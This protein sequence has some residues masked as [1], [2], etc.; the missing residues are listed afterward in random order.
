MCWG[1]RNYLT[2]LVPRVASHPSVDAVLVGMPQSVDVSHRDHLGDT[3]ELIS[4]RCTLAAR[5]REVNRP[6]KRKIERFSPD[7]IFIPTARH[8]RLNGIPVVNMVRNMMPATRAYS[9]DYIEYAKNWAR[10]IQMRQAV[11]KARRVIAVSKFVGRYLCEDLGVASENIGIVYHGTPQ[12]CGRRA[13]RPVLVSD[14]WRRR[15]VF[16]AGSIYPYRGIEDVILACARMKSPPYVV[17]AGFVGHRMGKYH[18][19]LKE[20]VQ[21]TRLS[22]QIRFVGA[23]TREEMGWCYQNCAAFVMSSR[24]EACPNIAL[25][26]MAHGCVCISTLNPPMPEIFGDA[27]RY[28]A[29]G[30][31]AELVEQLTAALHLSVA[32]QEEAR[33]EAIAT[34]A[35]FSW[36]ACCEK[37]IE[38]LQKVA[39][40]RDQGDAFN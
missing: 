29:A 34:A 33:H 27:A 38:E 20:L 36:D 23:L 4:L 28:Y 11:H 26:A 12:P 17:I 13:K 39:H 1:Y 15:F 5:G 35:K 21:T 32:Q 22:S 37:T 18:D 6:E 3:V 7:V 2:E 14:E 10:L 24:V 16:M 30:D 8:W 31:S 40:N 9:R 25:E 19:R